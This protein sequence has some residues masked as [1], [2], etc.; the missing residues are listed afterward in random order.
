M[1]EIS[2]L[3]AGGGIAA[4]VVAGW[5]QVKAAFS[6]VSSFVMV[7]ADLDDMLRS[8]V[9]QHLRYHEWKLVPGG[10][11]FYRS[12]YL[13]FREGGTH[14][15]PFR[16][17]PPKAI[18]RKGWRLLFVNMSTSGHGSLTF[19]R[20]T[21]DLDAFVQQSIERSSSSQ[22]TPVSRYCVVKVFGREK[23]AW[24]N[25]G[26]S[27]NSSGSE[28]PS[29]GSTGG[30]SLDGGGVPALHTAL[31]KSFMHDSAKWV[32]N[33]KD[34]PFEN[35]YFGQEVLKYIEQAL[36]WKALEK[37]HLERKV[38]WR[39]GWLL[40]GPPGTGKSS[41]AK[42]TAQS[43]G[44]PIYQ[45][46]LSTLS[47]QELVREWGC[48]ETPC[49]ALLEDFDNIFKGRENVTDNKSLTFD[50]VLNVISGV[51]ARDGV[52]LM[53]TTNH[54]EH[55]DP[56]MGVTVDGDSGIS[57]RPGRID[58]AIK[59]GYMDRANRVRLANR[60]L[61]DWPEEVE[62]LVRVHPEVT[63]AQFE[64]VCVQQAYKLLAEQTAAGTNHWFSS[65]LTE[66]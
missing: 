50:C 17:P 42:A 6:Y 48:M 36:I 45:Y 21:L 46:N 35:L 14:C 38:P 64:E 18:Y 23:G 57:T 54:L 11:L 27:Q 19:V 15:V 55:I 47:D 22:L 30:A 12:S 29:A 49:V 39:R 41:L 16:L 31:D 61:R 59:V 33:R 53:V 7:T 3:L 20:G 62:R 56:A 9:I 1:P 60:I 34:D 37:W 8:Q 25:S 40:Y 65:N 44:I 66:E 43:L 32:F 58:T 5:S 10:K 52:F 63:P 51:D 24:A 13:Y 2:N 26:S 4:A 28:A